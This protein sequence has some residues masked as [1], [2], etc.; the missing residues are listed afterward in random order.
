[1]AF[2]IAPL[3]VHSDAVPPRAR[4]A[5]NRAF[6]AAPEQRPDALEQA[7]RIL[8][9]ETDLGCGDV[10]ELVGLGPGGSCG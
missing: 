10:R 9:R 7:A 1:M 8:Y 3:L 2:S 6:L 4:D 5:L